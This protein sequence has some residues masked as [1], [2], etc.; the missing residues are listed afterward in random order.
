MRKLEALCR[1]FGS[2]SDAR[3]WVGERPPG[4]PS[5]IPPAI[6]RKVGLPTSA[7]D[8]VAGA[9]TPLSRRDAGRIFAVAG[10]TSLAYDQPTPGA[11]ALDA[12]RDALDDL[13][14]DAAFLSN[15]PWRPD[16]PTGWNPLTLATFDCGLIGFDRRSAF[17]FW[18]E[19]ED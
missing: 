14:D 5:H 11:N 9:L 18:V 8:D 2:Q 19:D 6:A 16:A 17:I 12:A 3:W 1:R 15:G 10:T 4:D 7:L 13:G